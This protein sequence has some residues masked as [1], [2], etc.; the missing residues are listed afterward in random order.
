MYVSFLLKFI[1][2]FIAYRSFSI[3]Y[4]PSIYTVLNENFKLFMFHWNVRAEYS[5]MRCVRCHDT[6]SLLVVIRV[7]RVN[8][9]LR[10]IVFENIPFYCVV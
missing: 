9:R 2:G 7:S 5:S 8:I 1:L 3:L 6:I 4:I 10:K